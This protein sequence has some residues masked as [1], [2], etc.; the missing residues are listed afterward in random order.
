MD[1]YDHAT[2]KSLY[3]SCLLLLTWYLL[4]CDIICLRL[5]RV[6]LD[7][8]TVLSSNYL[9]IFSYAKYPKTKSYQLQMS[10]PKSTFNKLIPQE[11][12]DK[13]NVTDTTDTR[14][15]QDYG[16]TKQRLQS[17][18]KVRETHGVS[19]H[20]TPASLPD[21]LINLVFYSSFPPPPMTE[22]SAFE[23][24]PGGSGYCPQ[25]ARSSLYSSPC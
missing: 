9:L 6:V 11:H 19:N 12:D 10:S 2:S 22:A 20:S 15:L 16:Y 17:P 5:S 21:Q 18:K 14:E 24:N 13:I 7:G 3:S 23:P 1:D 4:A 25:S 8:L